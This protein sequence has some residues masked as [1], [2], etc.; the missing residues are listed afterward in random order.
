MD[1]PAAWGE[2]QVCCCTVLIC[3]KCH[4]LFIH[5]FAFGLWLTFIVY[6]LGFYKSA[7]LNTLECVQESVQGG[8]PGGTSLGLKARMFHSPGGSGVAFQVVNSRH[9]LSLTS[10]DPSSWLRPLCLPRNSS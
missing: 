1:S 6:P 4:M 5:S 9:G 10:D 8:T 7:A 3:L 2:F